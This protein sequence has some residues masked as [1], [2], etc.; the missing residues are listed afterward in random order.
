MRDAAWCR[1]DAGGKVD[2]RPTAHAKAAELLTD[3]LRRFG[4]ALGDD[5]PDVVR[6]RAS[7]VTTYQRMG[8]TQDAET[9]RGGGSVAPQRA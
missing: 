3:T 7:L 4:R 6:C 2:V 1:D 5:H 8:R 9:V